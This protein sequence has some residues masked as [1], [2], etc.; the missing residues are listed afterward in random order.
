MIIGLAG[1]IGSGKD[2]FCK[3]LQYQIGIKRNLY[4]GFDKTASLQ[5]YL[6]FTPIELSM[7][8]GV[9]NCKFADALKDIACRMLGCTREQLEDRD[10]KD[11][12]LPKEWNTIQYRYADGYIDQYDEPIPI[13]YWQ[14]LQKLGTQAIRNTVHV[15]A[16]VNILMR[17]YKPVP[18]SDY[19]STHYRGEAIAFPSGEKYPDWVISDCRFPNEAQAIKDKGGI[20][21]KLIRHEDNTTLKHES[22]T[23]LQ[24]WKFDALVYNTGTIEDLVRMGGEF[25]N[26]FKLAEYAN[27]NTTIQGDYK[28]FCP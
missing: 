23:A 20:V 17:E 6:E 10:F 8:S 27:T 26:H 14:F 16:W 21:V 28:V 2:E 25:V 11:S 18:A 22:E 1:D 15:N 7:F 12:Y 4:S 5:D 3:I 19:E 9:Q 24:N 13:T